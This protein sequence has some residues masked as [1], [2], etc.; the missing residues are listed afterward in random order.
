M[1]NAIN[2]FEIPARDIERAR[3]FYEGIFSF[4]MHEL[5]I[6]DGL[7]MALFPAESGTVG[8]TIIQ[9]DDWYKPSNSEGPL[10][11]LN[12]NPD[13]QKVLDRVEEAGGEIIIPKRLITEE[14]GYMAVIID[15]EGNRVALHSNE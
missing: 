6:G 4:E 3:K 13:L 14:N 12:A 7:R 9:N 8:G 1:K 2:W 15:S 11:Y 5:D 10:L